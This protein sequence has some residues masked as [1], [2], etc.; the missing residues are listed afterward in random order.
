MWQIV[1][2]SL[3]LLFGG[4][5]SFGVWILRAMARQVTTEAL[6]A[7]NRDPEAHAAIVRL[8]AQSNDTKHA[9]EGISNA[10]AELSKNVGQLRE[11]VALIK[12][13]LSRPPVRQ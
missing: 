3:T 5:G 12:G 7:H 9:L 8:L 10:Q 2:L 1:G 11:D 13:Q 4:L 6:E